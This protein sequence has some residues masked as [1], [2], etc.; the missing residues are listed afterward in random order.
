MNSKKRRNKN[1]KKKRLALFIIVIVI[2]ISILG[3]LQNS[4]Q[5][6]EVSSIISNNAS[7]NKVEVKEDPIKIYKANLIAGGDALL[8]GQILKAAYNSE[9]DSYNFSHMLSL[10]KDK[11]SQYDIK[12]YN[13][14]VIFDDDKPYTGYP[15]FNAP[16]AWGKNMVNDFGFNLVSLATNHSMDGRLNSAKKSATSW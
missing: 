10:I 13:Q 15:T 12:Y 14:E 1:L 5:T 4:N 11:I 9:T 16:S 2:F 3:I 7:E 8:H 6:Q